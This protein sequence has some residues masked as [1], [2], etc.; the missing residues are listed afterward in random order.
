MLANLS[1]A[2]LTVAYDNALADWALAEKYE[3]NAHLRPAIREHLE[4]LGAE[5]SR[6]RLAR[7]EQLISEA[8]DRAYAMQED[9]PNVSVLIAQL[10]NSLSNYVEAAKENTL[11][12]LL[13]A[14]NGGTNG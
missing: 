12:T 4:A 10:A 7:D 5:R 1:D 9:A 8:T 14:P 13:R 6:R 3:H 2:D 11:I